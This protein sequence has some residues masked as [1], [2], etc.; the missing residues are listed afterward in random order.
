MQNTQSDKK[1]P[2]ANTH[3]GLT[4]KDSAEIRTVKD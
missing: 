4:N 2:E 3:M 1:Q